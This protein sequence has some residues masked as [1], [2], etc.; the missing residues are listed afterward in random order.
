MKRILLIS[1]LLIFILLASQPDFSV[2]T[3]STQLS[4]AA[5]SSPTGNIYYVSPGGN[6][7]NSGTSAADP[8]KT[9]NRAWIDIYPGDTLVLMDGTYYQSLNP[10]KRNGQPG[11]P[12][13]IRAQNDGKAIVDGQYQRLP[14]KIGDTWPG[15]IS[16]YFVIEGIVARNSSGQVITVTNGDNNI[17]RRISAYNANTDANTSALS[18]QQGSD[19]NLVEDC[20]VS[21]TGR[22]MI[23]I[24]Q[25]NGNTIRRCFAD[26]RSWDGRQS[27][28][29]WPW[30]DNIQIY[31]GSNNTIENSIG[32]GSVPFWSISIQ[33]NDPS[34]KAVGNRILGSIAINAGMNP[35]GTPKIWGNTRPQ[36]TSCT[37]MLQ[38]YQQ[39][40]LR[41]GFELYGQGELRNNTFQDIFAWGNAGLGF[42]Y[43]PNPGGGVH[44]NT[45][46]NHVNRATILGNGLDQPCTAWP[47]KGGG[48]DT[49][50][51]LEDI[52]KPGLDP[53]TDSYIEKIFVD[54]PTF[55]NGTRNLTSMNGAGARLTHRYVDGVLTNVPL[56][57]W[58]MAGRIQAE[59]GISIADQVQTIVENK[60]GGFA[61][62][63]SPVLQMIN[64]GE[65]TTVMVD[66]QPTSGFTHTIAV[67]NPSP[68]SD[69]TVDPP[70]T[71]LN[72]PGQIMLSLTDNHPVSYSSGQMYTV[73]VTAAGGGVTRH[74]NIY[75]LVN[76]KQAFLPTATSK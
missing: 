66:I 41:A 5:I 11:N 14:V 31:G 63:A 46:N 9:F 58:P 12:I 22:K 28:Q 62:S 25:S 51:R 49:D 43:N 10:N 6:D 4:H 32:Y 71:P 73:P 7:G 3:W 8:W 38:L 17:F 75:V 67:T 24:Y 56:W 76:G 44:P 47:C 34:L 57:P 42:I 55:P 74:T 37:G 1:P 30:G 29:L 21:G 52:S 15:P 23:Q 40:S 16:S 20:V 18:I 2:D 50:V 48:I 26:W 65:T 36:P 69:L 45:A 13:T 68:S 53:V 54:W 70:S 64:P 72:P 60:G 59:L 19:N 61:L 35:D 39:P 33:A 27:C